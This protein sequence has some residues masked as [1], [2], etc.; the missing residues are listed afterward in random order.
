ML[1]LVGKGR[2]FEHALADPGGS[3]TDMGL[4]YLKLY[5]FHIKD[6]GTMP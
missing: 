3:A 5:D 2:L 6:I 1:F 4:R